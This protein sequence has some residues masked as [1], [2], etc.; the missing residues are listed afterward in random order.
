M[1]RAVLKFALVLTVALADRA[2]N[3]ACSSDC[4]V[5]GDG[6]GYWYDLDPSCA[7]GWD[8]CGAGGS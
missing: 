1:R 3:G 4:A 5:L 2:R 8:V 7:G 6:R